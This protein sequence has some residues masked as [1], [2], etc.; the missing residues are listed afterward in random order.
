MEKPTTIHFEV[1]RPLSRD[2]METIRLAIVKVA[3][4]V[5]KVS[6]PERGKRIEKMAI[7]V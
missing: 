6:Y 5:K 2:E 1:P 3:G 7:D 4:S